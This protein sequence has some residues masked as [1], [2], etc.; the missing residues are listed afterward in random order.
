MANEIGPTLKTSVQLQ[1]SLFISIKSLI[2]LK[3][4]CHCH[5]GYNV[6]EDNDCTMSISTIVNQLKMT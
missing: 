5:C 1:T 6:I 3:Y 4:T 2:K